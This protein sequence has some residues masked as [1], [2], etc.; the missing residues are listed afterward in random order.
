MPDN[1]E[2]RLFSP[3]RVGPLALKN[4]V[5]MAPMTT[6]KA[7]AAGFVTED[8]IAYY[9]AR[10]AG[11]VG[12]ITVEMA[13]PERAGKHRHFE[14]GLSDDRFLPGLSRLVDV[15][16]AAGAKACIQIGH[17]G[18][19]TRV[20]ISGETPIAPSAI[21]HSV[22]EGHT[23]VIV[24]EAMSKARIARTVRSFAEAAQRAARAGFDA[25][26][27]HAA[28][29]YLISQ[30]MAPLENRREDD[31]GGTLENRARFALE[32]TRA[33]KAAMPRLAVIFRMNGDDFF[34]GG[35]TPDEAV[36]I[37]A[38]AEAAGADAIHVTGGHYR[39]QPSAAIMIPPMATA[40]TPFLGFAAAVKAVVGIP[41]I[42]VGRFGDP[43]SAEAALAAGQ[44]DFIALGRPLLAD[45]RWV[46]ETQ[47]GRS[48]RRCIACNTCVDGMRTG[49]QLHCL[50]NPEAGRER[51]YAE[52]RPARSGQRIAVIGGG[53]AGLAYASLMAGTNRVTL[54]E[55][56]AELGGAFRLAGLAPLFQGVAAEPTS[57]TDHIAALAERCRERGVAIRTRTD[58]TADLAMLAGFDHVVIATGA[59]YRAG[60]GPLV[61]ATL[62][63]GLTRRR[64]LRRLAVREDLRDW[65]YHRARKASGAKIA[66]AI[67]GA[68]SFTVEIIGDALAPGKSE[69]AIA[70]AFAA[71][72]RP[73][74]EE[75]ATLQK[76]DADLSLD[77]QRL[78]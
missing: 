77:G 36:R 62:R 14:L 34:E 70:S 72:Y 44:A 75:H 40:R 71:A 19:H 54:F 4:R 53:P 27:I 15:I 73:L 13:A 69:P 16:H 26:E 61:A 32:I 67:A 42:S 21:R 48:V 1:A 7:D 22:Q 29:G 56:Q 49:R 11:G 38:W 68:G 47:A 74:D 6:R 65:F 31:Y 50:V 66:A 46:A 45:P 52:R 76:A 33:V 51:E 9:R 5:I 57:L 2:A 28:H 25:V 3:G 30:F 78:A 24:P 23:E 60:A 37:A 20:D 35:L 43:A 17:G 8:G 63:S 59:E 12:L 39:S 64:P 41:V 55:K 58:V 18:G 10:A